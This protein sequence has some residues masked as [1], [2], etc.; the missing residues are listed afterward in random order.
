[1]STP[2]DKKIK[3]WQR[4]GAV[5]LAL[6]VW[7]AASWAVGSALLLPGPVTV[8]GRLCALAVTAAFRRA[9]AFSF[10]R[11]AG[12]FALALVLAFVLALAAGRW[13]VVEV[14]L[15]PYVLA[16]KAVPVA[17][18][19]ILVYLWLPGRWLTTFISA[20]MG[21]PPVYLNLLEGLARRDR[22]LAEMARVFRVPWGRR[23]WRLDLPQLLPYLR[24]AVSLGLGLCW[25][26]GVAAEV[27]GV[28]RGSLGE[29][30]YESKIYFEMPELFAWTVSIVALSALFERLAMAGLE[31]FGRKAG[32]PW[33]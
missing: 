24:S 29:R 17:S 28:V 23:F 32:G 16:I 22:A 31:R 20:L 13:P 10:C 4:A 2:A 7:Q 26:A 21:F 30:L 8:L 6:S 14:L 33:N 11:I 19:I 3:T 25:K 9:V 15:R 18:F 5:V 27:I 12:G 1:M